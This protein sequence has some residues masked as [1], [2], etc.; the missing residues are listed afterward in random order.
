MMQ[1]IINEKRKRE[2]QRN[3]GNYIKEGLLKIKNEEIRKFVDFFLINAEKSLTTANLLMDVSLNKNLKE[4]LKLHENFETYLWV[5]VTAYYSM[6]YSA[7]ALLASDG[8]RI[9]E[10]I[11]H[12]VVS[13]SLIYFFIEN[14]RLANL[15]ADYEKAKND[16]LEIIGKE[17]YNKQAEKLVQDFEF[18]RVKR[19][20]VQYE[21]GEIA[22]ENKARTSLERAKIFMLEIKKIL[23]K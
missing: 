10:K 20:R 8:T 22:I 18:E 16:A 12:K 7:L 13:D 2:A 4:Q 17:E 9:G 3:V 15:L 6:F 19:G 11:K 21:I 23:E 5:T 1:K 14:K